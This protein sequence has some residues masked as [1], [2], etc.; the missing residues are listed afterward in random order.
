M[1]KEGWDITVSSSTAY[2]NSLIILS[3]GSLGFIFGITKYSF[4][5]ACTAFL[6]L[7]LVLLLLSI[8][9]SLLSFWFEQLHGNALM[10]YA[11]LCYIDGKE[12][13]RTKKP[14]SYYAAA[15]CKFLAGLLFLLSL[16]LFSIFFLNGIK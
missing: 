9:C 3:T 10:L 5:N 12:E 16:I 11:D 7:I 6:I 8:L 13:Y 14:W 2:D 1:R 15:S 4:T